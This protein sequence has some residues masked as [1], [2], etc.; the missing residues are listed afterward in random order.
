MR[1]EPLSDATL[2]AAAGL[3]AES[4]ARGWD[5]QAISDLMRNGAA[6]H[7]AMD[8]QDM[9]GFVLWRTVIEEAEL[10]TIVVTAV[11]RGQGIGRELLRVALAGTRK[12]GAQCM[13]LEVAEDNAAAIALYRSHNFH[14]ISR[15]K[16]Y[17]D[18]GIGVRKD[19][20]VMRREYA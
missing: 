18:R 6:G 11:R 1:I 12:S 5:A 8:E 14:V 13:F 3:H 17:Y 2:A 7:A 20:L 19:A 9:L 16:A 10:L 4:F 15:R